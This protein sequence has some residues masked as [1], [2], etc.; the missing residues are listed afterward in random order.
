MVA[1]N[2]ARRLPNRLNNSSKTTRTI[3]RLSFCS[4]PVLATGG[5]PDRDMIA[6]MYDYTRL[7]Q[8]KNL[9]WQMTDSVVDHFDWLSVEN[10][11]KG[12]LIEASIDG[13]RIKLSTEN[14]DA[15]TVWLDARLIDPGQPVTIEAFGKTREV[16]YKPGLKQ[17][18]ESLRRT[19]DV[20]LS[21]DFKVDLTAE[22]AEQ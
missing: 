19:G 9:T 14:L 10:P 8:P 20:H 21:Y 15:V 16:V 11:G 6:A 5:L 22:T 13:N 7:N 4:S 1:A 2:G 18:C 3:T 12:K 17:F